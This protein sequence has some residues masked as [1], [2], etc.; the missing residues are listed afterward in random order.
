MDEKMFNPKTSYGLAILSGILLLLSFPPFKFGGFLAWVAFVPILVATYY[1]IKIG[2]TKK[3]IYIAGLCILPIFIWIS[4]DVILMWC[5]TLGKIIDIP[6]IGIIIALLAG[7]GLSSYVLGTIGEYSWSKQFPPKCM[8]YLPFK[9]MVFTIPIVV[10]AGEFL[11][12][13]LPAIMKMGSIVGFLSVSK[14]QWLNLPVL[15]LASITG[16]YGITFLVLVVNTALAYGV[17]KYKEIKQIPKQTIAVVTLLAV[18]FVCG[19]AS[20]PEV[21]S[22][23][24]TVILIQAKP[25]IMET[26][27]IN[28]LYINLSKESLK[29]NPEIIFWPIWV[30]PFMELSSPK[31]WVFGP[32]A[33]EYADFSQDNNV[34]LIDSGGIICPDGNVHTFDFPFHYMHSFEGIIPFEPSKIIPEAQGVNT[35]SGR[36]GP[37]GCIE[38]GST[39]PTNKLVDDGVRFVAV[40]TG[41]PPLIIDAAPGLFRANIV[42]RAVE[43]RIYSAFPYRDHESVIIDPYGRLVEDIAPEPEIVA[44]K[45]FFTD[46][47][48]F[49]TKYGDIFGWSIVGLALMLVICDFYFKRKSPFKYCVICRSKM[50]KEAKICHRCGSNQP[51]YWKR[52]WFHHHYDRKENKF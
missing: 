43:H 47:K 39:L 27:H 45:I 37:L 18:I 11:L 1:E 20:I 40:F 49:Y 2:R 42:Y 5:F 50:E 30:A 13:N 16:M 23:D 46:E 35:H 48:T 15:Q 24:T 28:E 3:F 9:W 8:R 25:E 14:T 6:A 21:E 34:Y 38:C 29:Y 31:R 10:T 32:S 33:K 19:W 51:S 52:F 4:Y 17:I 41:N 7:W 26:E 12:M 36:F 44:G 22:G